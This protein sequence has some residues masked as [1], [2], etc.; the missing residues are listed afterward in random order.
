MSVE[1][2]YNRMKNSPPFK[3]LARKLESGDQVV[4]MRGGA[5]SLSAFA[6][7]WIEESVPGPVVVACADEERAEALRNDLER[8]VAKMW[9]ISRAGMWR[10]G[11]GVPRIWTWWDCGWKHWIS[12]TGE[13]V[14]SSLHRLKP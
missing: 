2:L 13:R 3:D 4:T 7:A 11:M 9:D 14:A 10:I 12:C 1:R 8:L 5:G 6:I